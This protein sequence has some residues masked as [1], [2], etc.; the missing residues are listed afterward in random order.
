[1]KTYPMGLY[2]LKLGM[3][4]VFN[5]DGTVFP[6]T[7][8]QI[9]PNTVLK[10]KTDDAIDGYN[11]VQVGVGTQKASRQSRSLRGQSR[12]A[13]LEETPPRHIREIRVAT[14][15]IASGF[16]VGSTLTVADVFVA[17][18]RVD[19]MGTSKGKGFAGV[20]KRHHFAGFERSH[21]VHE[22]FR[23]GGSIGTRLTPGHTFKGKRMGGHMGDE[24]VTMQ[25]LDLVKVDAERGI[26]FIR[27]G[28]PGAPGGLVFVRRAIKDEV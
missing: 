24:R 27:G 20:M 17:G 11:S 28:I 16:T 10:V 13:G 26:L 25:N 6:V 14:K 15:A 4:Q 3:T 18:K 8:V 22:Y 7:L 2:G 23:H 1:M 12:A 21:G 5:D 19:A 9:T